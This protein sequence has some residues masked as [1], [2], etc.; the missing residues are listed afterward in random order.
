MYSLALYDCFFLFFGL[1]PGQ[2]SLSALVTSAIRLCNLWDVFVCF[3][4]NLKSDGWIL[5][6]FSGIVQNGTL[7]T[8]Y[9]ILVVIL[10]TIWIQ[11]IFNRFLIIVLISNIGGVGAWQ[12]F[13]L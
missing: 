6:K 8:D 4:N 7:G 2:H 12:R 11:E 3:Q 9:E 13:A 10:I 1:V 5:M